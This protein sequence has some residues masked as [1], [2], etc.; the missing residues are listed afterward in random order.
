MSNFGDPDAGALYSVT[1]EG[2]ITQHVAPT[3][4]SNGL[5]WNAAG[6]KFWYIDTPTL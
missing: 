6:T 4:I 3:S 1:G 5:V 2:T